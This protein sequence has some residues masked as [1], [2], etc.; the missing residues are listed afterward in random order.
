MKG[1]LALETIVKFIIIIFVFGMLIMLINKWY[2]ELQQKA[3]MTISGTEPQEN[4]EVMKLS[5]ITTENF[6]QLLRSCYDKWH[7]KTPV[8]A[9][10]TCYVITLTSGENFSNS[11]NA[12][13]IN[14]LLNETVNLSSL[15]KSIVIISYRIA[16]NQV[17]VN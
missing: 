8:H 9:E 7:Q 5:N 6:A 12:T 3:M 15:N 10:E 16:E 17:F 11:V 2:A 4:L 13:V 14:D 1:E